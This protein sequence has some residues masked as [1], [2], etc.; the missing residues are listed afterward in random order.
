MRI[1]RFA[2]RMFK[3]DHWLDLAVNGGDCLRNLEEMRM[4]GPV[5]GTLCYGLTQRS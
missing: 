3:D 5:S 4:A 2:S 1:P